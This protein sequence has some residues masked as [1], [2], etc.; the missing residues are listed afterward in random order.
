MESDKDAENRQMAIL[1]FHAMTETSD[2]E[3]ATKYLAANNW[4]VTVRFRTST[5]TLESGGAIRQR[6]CSE[7]EHW[8]RKPCARATARAGPSSYR[9]H[10]VTAN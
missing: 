5:L 8:R 3:I 9:P 1:N 10:D 6:E 7:P 4:D 2:S